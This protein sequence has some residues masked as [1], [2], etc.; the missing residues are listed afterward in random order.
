MGS[1][2]EESTTEEE[3]ELGKVSSTHSL[4]VSDGTARVLDATSRATGEYGNACEDALC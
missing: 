3:Q 2:L 1:Q 4:S